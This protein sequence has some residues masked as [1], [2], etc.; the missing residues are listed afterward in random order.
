MNEQERFLVFTL[1][2]EIFAIPLLSVREVIGVP[3]T[4]P[5]PQMPNYFVGVMNLRG[6]V[7][8]I[9]DL[10]L[11]FNIKPQPTKEEAVLVMEMGSYLL[12]GIV[13]SV[14]SVLS[15]DREKIMPPPQ[16]EG[17]KTAQYV[18]GVIQVENQLVLVLDIIKALSQSDKLAVMQTQKKAA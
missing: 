10:R 12:G 5:I 6:S 17:S 4:T 8:T 1:G 15:V 11:K 9:L 13:D 2:K 16:L 14:K 7:V 18:T 3:E